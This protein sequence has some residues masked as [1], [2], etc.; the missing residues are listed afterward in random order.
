VTTT[1]DD[2]RY[3]WRIKPTRRRDALMTCAADFLEH[4]KARNFSIRTVQVHDFHIARF[5]DFCEERG[6]VSVHDVTRP[7]VV[8]FQRFLFYYRAKTGRPLSASTQA[9]ALGALRA[10]FRY[11]TKAGVIHANPAADL[12]LPRRGVRLPRNVFTVDEVERILR[13]IDLNNAMALRDR[14]I[15]E[16]LYSTGIR[17]TELCCLKVFD[18]DDE[19]GILTV[20][21]GKG[22][23]DR[24][25]PIGERALLWVRKYLDLERHLFALEPDPL[26]LFLTDEG[27]ALSPDWLSE[28]VRRHIDNAGIK[29]AGSCHVFRHTMA[30]LMLEGGADIRHIQA[31]LGHASLEST[32]IYTRV[33][34]EHLKKVHTMAHP[35]KMERAPTTSTKPTQS[36]KARA[37]LLV[38]LDAELDVERDQEQHG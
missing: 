22:N 14:A 17:R 16:T 13:G 8:R 25:V 19:R 5:I 18:L 35:A 7:V 12:E 9:M 10:M 2:F 24:V 20:R 26:W 6:I 29:K 21:A 28:A 27:E 30:T 34:I 1:P 33:S 38:E 37:E 3:V 11:F 36:E 15:I 31:M 32:Q 23:K 4:E